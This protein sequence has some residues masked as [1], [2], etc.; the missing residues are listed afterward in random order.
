MSRRTVSF[1]DF[2]GGLDLRTPPTEMDPRFTP[3]AYNW[4]ID[5][6]GSLRAL[7]GSSALGADLGSGVVGHDLAFYETAGGT[8]YGIVATGTKWLHWSAAGTTP[9][10]M[11]DLRTG[12]TANTDTTF[13]VHNDV[14][15]GLDPAND[16][17]T[18]D[19]TT[20]TSHAP[21]VDD[22]PPQGIILGIWDG[23]MW[24]RTGAGGM[25]IR[26]SEVFDATNGFVNTV[27]MWP[28]ANT[29]TLGG[30]AQSTEDIL[31]GVPVADGLFVYTTA[32]CYLLY[33]SDTGFNRL[34]DADGALNRRV[35]VKD[36][37]TI[38]GM[39]RKGIWRTNGSLPLEYVS[40]RVSR[41][42]D[43][44]GLSTS[45][46]AA[47]VF[48]GSYWVTF[49]PLAAS[50]A[51]DPRLI[52]PGSSSAWRGAWEV[53]LAT[54]SI[55]FHNSFVTG[56]AYCV[57]PAQGSY[58]PRLI[59]LAG[60]TETTAAANYGRYVR[61][62][63]AGAGEANTWA[64]YSLPVLVSE[65]E[66]RLRRITVTGQDSVSA[67][68]PAEIYGN[69]ALRFADPD[70]AGLHAAGV[71]AD[72]LGNLTWKRGTWGSYR[73]YDTG[74]LRAGLRG[75]ALA[76][77]FAFRAYTAQNLVTAAITRIDLEVTDLSR[78]HP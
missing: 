46:G 50:S 35:V 24:I 49:M 41:M 31:G 21:S 42:F 4:R 18:W 6:D 25:T 14:L 68:S 17:A 1:S 26:W 40:G 2:S 27:G 55:M 9:G 45:V 69:T 78:R 33:D 59:R 20:L 34:V 62:T 56:S 63:M 61:A 29:V 57:F 67:S 48:D 15:Y 44:I 39:N 32:G 71:P 65:R 11:T 52:L 47:V 28:T 54:G 5:G 22:G 8:P 60:D 3:S 23:R 53:D 75:R 37:D 16:I 10:T 36:G 12:M 13:V 72:I 66:M 74:Y 30:S 64:V 76:L 58:S 51:N 43:E 7:R 73:G 70:F 19:G 38:W 77:A